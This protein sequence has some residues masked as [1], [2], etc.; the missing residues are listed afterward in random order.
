MVTAIFGSGFRHFLPAVLW[1][2]SASFSISALL[3]LVYLFARAPKSFQRAEV[4]AP[5]ASFHPY[6]GL[7]P[8]KQRSPP[9]PF[10]STAIRERE[11]EGTNIKSTLLGG[12][13]APLYSFVF[14]STLTG[15]FS[16]FDLSLA[17][18]LISYFCHSRLADKILPSYPPLSTV[19]VLFF[20]L[21][22]SKTARF[23]QKPVFTATVTQRTF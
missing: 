8:P 7:Y 11:E 20:T 1:R 23:Y 6:L 22:F 21:F 16:F 9:P 13:T 14:P 4:F 15:L 18:S 10:Y 19:R 2:L 5:F 3:L 12:E 17:I